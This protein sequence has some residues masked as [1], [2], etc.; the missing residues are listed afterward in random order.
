MMIERD[1][2]QFFKLTAEIRGEPKKLMKNKTKQHDH[3]GDW[4]ILA[5]M[6]GGKKVKVR[7]VEQERFQAGGVS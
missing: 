4:I 5:Y 2:W 6:F 3:S 7:T 1:Q